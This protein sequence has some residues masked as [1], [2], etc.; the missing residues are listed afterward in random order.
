MPLLEVDDVS[1]R[2]GGHLALSDVS[3][4]VEEG[5]ITGLIGPNGAGKTTLFNIC[6][7]LLSPTA[8]DVRVDG[9][10][11]VGMSPARRARVGMA[12]TFQRLELFGS[13]TVRE[14]I[15]VAGEI[16]NRWSILRRA[17]ID[18]AG[19][20]ERILRLLGLEDVA[21]REV[22]SVPTGQA[23]LV[24]LGRALMTRPRL[25]LLD[26]PASG[27]SDQETEVFGDLLRTL[28]DEGVTVLL[29][30]HDMSLVMSV[31]DSVH[32]LDFGTIISSGT[33]E[34]VQRDPRVLDA[35]LGAEP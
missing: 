10:S 6:S 2:F 19:E 26:E 8:G 34:D 4:D 22:A 9:G 5:T 29:V 32:V 31:C 7:G 30:E 27:Q 16:R 25:L 11:L 21:E 1:M 18:V 17:G 15:R 35:Y 24:E 14:N 13:L 28:G 12:R 33:P 3:I 23:R 20:T